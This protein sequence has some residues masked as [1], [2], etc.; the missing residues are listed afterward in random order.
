MKGILSGSW[1]LFC[2]SGSTDA[3]CADRVM[4]SAHNTATCAGG[5]ELDVLASDAEDEFV[6]AAVPVDLMM[7]F[8]VGEELMANSRHR[9]WLGPID[10]LD[11]SRNFR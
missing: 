8:V 3:V 10:V 1:H 5:L 6:L 4:V 7:R 2:D 11:S 9:L